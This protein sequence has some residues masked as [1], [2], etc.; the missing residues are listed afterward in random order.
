MSGSEWG[1]V[2]WPQPPRFSQKYCDTNGRRIAIQMGGVLRH[3]WEE[4]W[5]YSL[6]SERRGTKSAAVQIGGVVQYKWEVYCDTFLWSSGGWGFWHSSDWVHQAVAF[7][8]A[9]EFLD[10]PNWG[11][12]FCTS[13]SP[14]NSYHCK[15]PVAIMAPIFSKLVSR[16]WKLVS[17]QT[18]ALTSRKYALT[19]RKYAVTSQKEFKRILLRSFWTIFGFMA[20]PPHRRFAMIPT[21]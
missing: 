4:Y 17:K 7:A 6:S 15:P 8:I 21:H 2:R 13:V 3:K 14:I 9:S 19:S 1:T 20:H 10:G 18:Y 16:F 11:L 5:Q 12:F